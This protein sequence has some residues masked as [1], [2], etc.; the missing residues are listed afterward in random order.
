MPV[1]RSV[2][3]TSDQT[4]ATGSPGTES[5]ELPSVRV[6]GEVDNSLQV[7]NSLKRRPYE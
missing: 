4:A 5:A 7:R 6:L 3:E 1:G 2:L